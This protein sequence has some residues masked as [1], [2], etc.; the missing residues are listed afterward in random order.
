MTAMFIF[1]PFRRS[2]G[3]PARQQ[4][5]HSSAIRKRSSRSDC[6]LDVDAAA[7]LRAIL[8]ASLPMQQMAAVE[9]E[10]ARRG[11]VQNP[12][13]TAA[14]PLRP[15]RHGFAPAPHKD[16]SLFGRERL[17]R[18]RRSSL[19]IHRLP[20]WTL[21]KKCLSRGTGVTI[22]Q[23]GATHAS[24]DLLSM[25]CAISRKRHAAGR[26][27]DLRGRAAVCELEGTT[28]ALA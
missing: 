5:L 27:P 16:E 3:A 22:T 19:L 4:S 12:C 18:T 21:R 20:D 9:L 1:S 13:S 26:M 23:G 8:Y 7:S 17:G 10:R 24:L 15:L 28:M 14:A 11:R 25:R 2:V 6:G